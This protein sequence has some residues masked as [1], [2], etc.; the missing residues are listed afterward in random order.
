MNICLDE[1]GKYRLES[2]ELISF[3]NK[4]KQDLKQF[5]TEWNSTVTLLA[6]YNGWCTVISDQTKIIF[7]CWAGELIYKNKEVPGG[8]V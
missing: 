8:K 7:N 2:G 6:N 5:K 4:N 3:Y 1:K